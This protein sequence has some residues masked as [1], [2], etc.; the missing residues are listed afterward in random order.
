MPRASKQVDT[1]PTYTERVKAIGEK[2]VGLKIDTAAQC[3]EASKTLT[4]AQVLRREITKVYKDRREFHVREQRRIIAEEKSLTDLLKITETAVSELIKSFQRKDAEQRAEKEAKERATREEA[5]RA[6]AQL[7]A[8]QLRVAAAAA[9]S[10]AVARRL[11]AQAAIVESAQPVIDPIQVEDA[12]QTLAPGVHGRKSVHAA[13]DDLRALALQ[14][15][16]GIMLKEYGGNTDKGISAFLSVFKPSSQATMELLQPS[17]PRLND[18]AKA[19]PKDLELQGVRVVED[20]G[21]VGR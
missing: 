4:E 18:L 21:F 7:R 19:F 3:V 16:A 15:A 8:D 5:A 11:E 2:V 10:K 13:V 6:E 14:I 20:E 12:P 9:P 17:M 1:Q